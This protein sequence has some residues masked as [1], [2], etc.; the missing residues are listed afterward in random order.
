MGEW[1]PNDLLIVI[2]ACHSDYF[3]GLSVGTPNMDALAHGTNFRQAI[4]PAPWTFSSILIGQNPH[5]HGA[6]SQE[7][8]MQDGR[9]ATADFP[10]GGCRCIH[11]SPK[12]WIGDWLPQGQGFHHTEEFIRPAH[13]HVGESA[14]VCRETAIAKYTGWVSSHSPDKITERSVPE[15]V[16]ANLRELQ[17]H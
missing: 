8:E 6:H 13:C 4:S 3:R 14:D 1:K 11:A 10:A 9:T 17:Y 15:D 12:T 16:E 2:D 5:E 7:F